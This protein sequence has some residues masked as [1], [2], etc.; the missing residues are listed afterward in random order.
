MSQIGFVDWELSDHIRDKYPQ[1]IAYRFVLLEEAL[2]ESS[3]AEAKDSF[4]E[5]CEVVMQYCSAIAVQSYLQA[6]IVHSDR[7]TSM[8]RGLQ[9]KAF[10][11]GE[12]CGLL[13]ETLKCFI[14]YEDKLF[15]PDLLSFYY[16]NDAGNMTK[17]AAFLNKIP[18]IR[19]REKGHALRREDFDKVV[20]EYLP[21][22]GAML[23]E[24]DF[25][26]KYLMFAPS[27][28]EGNS[29]SIMA[30]TGHG[31][32][33]HRRAEIQ[34]QLDPGHAYIVLTEKFKRLVFDE[35][36]CLAPLVIYE[37]CAKCSE[38]KPKNQIFLFQSYME[39]KANNPMT[40]MAPSCGHQ[41]DIDTYVERLKQ[42]LGMMVEA[43]VAAPVKAASWEDLVERGDV[44]TR[45]YISEVSKKYDPNMYVHR[46]VEA[47][48]GKFMK[49][50]K[51]VFAL[52]GEGPLPKKLYIWVLC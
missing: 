41:I 51:T 24:L 10:S 45:R 48:F 1:P 34:A 26:R 18:N 30:F 38:T 40:Y 47:Q 6:E 22:V 21:Q 25:L 36:L 2:N 12:W 17:T 50:E 49:S 29:Y 16:K 5:L 33:A 13:R 8:I 9:K 15:V 28:R 23:S 19:N 4:I 32:P 42:L 20:M 37:R 46:G 3:W 11:V 14:G 52:M 27:N 44:S 31:R 35:V 43:V 7:T 39:E